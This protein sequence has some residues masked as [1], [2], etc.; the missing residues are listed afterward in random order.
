MANSIL[1]VFEKSENG[2]GKLNKENT[3]IINFNDTGK[4]DKS[5]VNTMIRKFGK[6]KD[7][8]TF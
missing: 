8:K 3:K 7:I 4:I 1:H 6:D 2:F 5:Y